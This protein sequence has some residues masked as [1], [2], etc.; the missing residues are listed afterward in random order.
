M[1]AK[2]LSLRVKLLVSETDHTP[3]S[4]ARVNKAW[5]YISTPQYVFMTWL[6][7]KHRILIH[8]TV[9]S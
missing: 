9:L 2:A 5:S 7:I 3:S 6:L 1:G 4:C 8:I